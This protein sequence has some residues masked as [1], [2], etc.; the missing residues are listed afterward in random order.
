MTNVIGYNKLPDYKEFLVLYNSGKT[1]KELGVIY[2]CGKIRIRKW[3][4][5]FGLKR[6]QQGGG[7]NRKFSI[8][9]EEFSYYI[10]EGFSNKE[11]A[12]KLGMSR[13]SV[14]QWLNKYGLIRKY[15]TSE[16]KSYA[17]KVR[18]Y[19][20]KNYT[21]YKETLNPNNFPRTL[22]GVSGGYQLDHIKSVRECFDDNIS[23]E[24]CSDV[25]N[26]QIIS[27]EENL[28]KRKFNKRTYNE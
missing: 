27:W 5:I 15:N 8:S 13:S 2:G 17:R 28:Q 18:Y 20:E 16:F 24:E 21:K 10:S 6:R 3:I 1:Q 25:N 11:I 26:L 22:C 19:S 9:K 12:H 7:N 4:D 23:I 14:E